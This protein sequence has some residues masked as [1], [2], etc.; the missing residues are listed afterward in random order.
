MDFFISTAVA[1]GHAQADGGLFGLMLPILLLVVFFFIFIRPQ[2]KKVKEHK[3]MTEELKK[4]DEIV[5]AG[6]VAGTVT[7]ISDAFVKVKIADDVEV[8]VQKHA[9]GNLLPKGTI[10][11]L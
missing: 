3:K 2:Q 1:E 10:K 7:Q 11:A 4:G 5:T 8:N 9:I 6:G